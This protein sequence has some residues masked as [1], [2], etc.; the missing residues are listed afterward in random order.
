MVSTIVALFD[1]KRLFLA[2][3]GHE[4]DAMIEELQNYEIHVSDEG[5]D[6]YGA[7]TGAHDDLVTALALSV[8]LGEQQSFAPLRMW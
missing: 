3:R 7:K 6:Q 8:W 5:R 4:T 1:A 2:K